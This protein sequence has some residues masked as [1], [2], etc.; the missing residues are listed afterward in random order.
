[1]QFNCFGRHQSALCTKRCDVGAKNKSGG[2]IRGGRGGRTH[3]MYCI[4]VIGLRNKSDATIG[5]ST[6]IAI[7]VSDERFAFNCAFGTY[8]PAIGEILYNM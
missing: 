8:I 5:V 2:G 3:C 7:K 4:L 1:M 6:S